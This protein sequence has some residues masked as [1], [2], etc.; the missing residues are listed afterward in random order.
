MTSFVLKLPEGLICLDLLVTFWR[1]TSH[2]TKGE[3]LVIEVR[4]I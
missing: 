2:V 3:V 4:I 1:N